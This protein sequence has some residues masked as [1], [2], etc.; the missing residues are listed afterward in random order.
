MPK[1]A[2]IIIE[3]VP[4]LSQTSNGQ[5]E[6]EILKEAQIPWSAKINKVEIYKND[7]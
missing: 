2:V 6:K 1:K 4:E 5:I 3:L 7:V